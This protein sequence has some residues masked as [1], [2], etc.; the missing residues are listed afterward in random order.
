MEYAM[1]YSGTSLRNIDAG[2]QDMTRYFLDLYRAQRKQLSKNEVNKLVLAAQAGDNEAYN[3]VLLENLSL[4]IKIATMYRAFDDL[5]DLVQQGVLGVMAAIQRFRP[6]YGYAFSTYAFH[7][8][9]QYIVRYIDC[10]S[11]TITFPVHLKE[12]FRKYEKAIASGEI[13]TGTMTREQR[14]K[15]AKEHN[16]VSSL[17]EFDAFEACYVSSSICSLDKP[18]ASEEGGDICLLMDNISTA[19]DIEAQVINSLL[20]EEI[21]TI[22]YHLLNEKELDIMKMR[23]GFECEPMT[24]Q[25]IADIYGLT[26]ERIRQIESRCLSKI[27]MRLKAL[28][29]DD[30][31]AIFSYYFQNVA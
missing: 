3:T 1:K 30:A 6:E 25:E 10:Y 7:W 4:A 26:R 13:Y 19:D 12:K 21:H 14:Y 15:A 20:K 18:I 16:L 29:H 2:S 17:D 23:M 8:I 5:D 27:R 28:Y 11:S 22:L 24:L 31:K 9:R